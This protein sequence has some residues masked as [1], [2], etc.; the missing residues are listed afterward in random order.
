LRAGGPAWKQPIWL[1][2]KTFRAWPISV[3]T[4]SAIF[5]FNRAPFF[6]SFMEVRVERSRNR[7]VFALHGAN[8]PLRWRDLEGSSAPASPSGPNDELAE[9]VIDF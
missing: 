3:E 2:V 8:G 5:D 1:W 7:V 6:Q 4:L 9:Y